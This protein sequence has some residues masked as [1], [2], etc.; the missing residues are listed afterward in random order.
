MRTAELDETAKDFQAIQIMQN[1]MMGFLNGIVLNDRVEIKT[2]LDIVGCS[3]CSC[4][5]LG[6]KVHSA[7]PTLSLPN[8]APNLVANLIPDQARDKA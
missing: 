8:L 2:L 1:K 5:Y 6:C 3:V 4:L 7:Y